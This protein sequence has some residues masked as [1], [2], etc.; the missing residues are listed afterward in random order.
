MAPYERDRLGWDD[1]KGLPIVGDP[2]MQTGRIRI[3]CANVSTGGRVEAVAQEP[4]AV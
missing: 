3:V 2:N 4:V 1:Y